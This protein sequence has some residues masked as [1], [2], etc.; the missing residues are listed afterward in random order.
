MRIDTV[1]DAVVKIFRAVLSFIVRANIYLCRKI[2]VRFKLNNR[3]TM[4]EELLQDTQGR[5][6]DAQDTLQDTRGRLQFISEQYQNEVKR[7]TDYIL[8]SLFDF[9]DA[10]KYDPKACKAEFFW[11]KQRLYEIKYV[12]C[13]VEYVIFLPRQPRSGKYFGCERVPENAKLVIVRFVD[14]ELDRMWVQRDGKISSFG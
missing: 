11:D 13:E 9:S 7:L 10:D 6:R 8:V 1:I 12:F 3:I 2:S 4:F 14:R 5:L